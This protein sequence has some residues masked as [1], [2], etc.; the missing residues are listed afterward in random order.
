M[1]V[2]DALRAN[3]EETLAKLPANMI[4]RMEFQDLTSEEKTALKSLPSWASCNPTVPC[5]SVRRAN[6]V[7]R[8][9]GHIGTVYIYV[10]YAN[11]DGEE[12]EQY[13]LSDLGLQLVTSKKQ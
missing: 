1:E 9:R 12:G 8:R 7:H 11:L 2:I 4:S 10:M 3:H 5:E 13:Q 6:V